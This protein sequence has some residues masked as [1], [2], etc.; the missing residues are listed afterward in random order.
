MRLFPTCLLLLA[1]SSACGPA[2]GTETI[3][4]SGPQPYLTVTPSA[5]ASLI[6]PLTHAFL[7]TATPVVYVVV[8]GDTLSG[9]AARNQISLEALIAANPGIQLSVLS[10]G[11]KLNIPVG[12]ALPGESTPTPLPLA[13]RQARCWP[14]AEG[15]L[16][17][18]AAVENNRAESVENLSAQ[19]TL[20]SADGQTGP[21]QVAF[22]PLDL[23]PTGR[24][25][26]IA[27]YFP[28]P[29]PAE[30]APRLELLTSI[31][32]P[33]GDSRYLPVAIQDS[34][35]SVDW[36]GRSA[37]VSGRVVL[38]APTGSAKSL[39][40]LGVAYDS[41][42]NVVGVRRWEAATALE[43]GKDLRFDFMI[44]SVGPGIARVEFL[45]EARP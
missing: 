24:S 14:G 9:I 27:A 39:W 45:T 29:V 44:S 8:S 22:A 36:S 10:V 7:P 41:A 28:P 38:T 33:P 40:V 32:L 15:G 13:V 6:P 2:A 25:M 5:T 30:A 3:T 26:P 17:C 1:F 42:G 12:S 37:Q 35:V 19:F 43:A 21:S 20:L 34:L 11:T 4:S 16:W 23:L 31:R 18:F